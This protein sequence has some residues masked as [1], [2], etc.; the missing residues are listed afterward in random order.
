MIDAIKRRLTEYLVRSEVSLAL[1]FDRNGRIL[2]HT[3]RRITGDNVSTGTGFAQSPIREV[4][5]SEKAIDRDMGVQGMGV[6]MG[7]SA[8][9]VSARALA[10]CS[11]SI[12][13]LGS[14]LFLYVDSGSKTAFTAAER[15][16]FDTL[17]GLLADALKNVRERS[18]RSG[19]L[20]GTSSAMATVRD[21]AA[22]YAVEE[23]P[24]LIVGETGVGKNRV[25]ELIHQASGRP[26]PLVVAHV[27]SLPDDLVERELFGHRRGAFTG[28]VTDRPGLFDEA[29]NGTLL[30]DEITEV[31]LAVQA[32]LLRVVESRRFRPVGDTKERKANVRL[33]AATNRNLLLDVKERRFREDLYFRLGILKLPIPPLRDRPD[34]IL[35]TA[36]EYSRLL[37]GKVL[38]R[39]AERVLV[40]HPWPGNVRELLAILTRAGI[41]FDSPVIGEEIQRLLPAAEPTFSP[42]DTLPLIRS[43]L[44]TGASFWDAVWPSF[45]DRDLNRE[46]MTL[47]LRDGFNACGGSLTRLASELNIAKR[48][49]ARFVSVIHKYDI[50]PRVVRELSDSKG[51]LGGD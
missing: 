48:D 43:K 51:K 24:V 20:A 22:R 17:G 19:G 23:E 33:L 25:A 16:V 37:R 42:R 36:R 46:Q 32:K 47:L 39:S 44:A 29:E 1:I 13:P 34:D 3:G 28:A 4:L 50:H 41:E 38:D 11:L 31:P 9:S 21:L 5:A 7:K 35:C 45:L 26:G 10:I 40:S 12:R 49:Y 30:L 2:W 14:G 6:D 8:L 15:Q 18:P 27:P